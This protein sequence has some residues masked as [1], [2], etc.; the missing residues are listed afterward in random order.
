MLSQYNDEEEMVEKRAL[1]FA[2]GA[3]E[4]WICAEDGRMSF[5]DSVG[6]LDRS[7]FCPEF[8]LMVEV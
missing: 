1:Y 8:P 7:G 5:Y 6:A 3:L 2:A 4:C